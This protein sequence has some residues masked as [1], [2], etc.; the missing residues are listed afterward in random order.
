MIRKLKYRKWKKIIEKSELFDA[1]YYLFTYS[2]VRVQDIDPIK[3]YILHGVKEGRNPNEEFDT[4]FY[5]AN[6]PDVRQSNINP[7]VHYILYG[8]KENRKTFKEENSSA[9]LHHE[10]SSSQ[11]N[12]LLQKAYELLQK[13]NGSKEEFDIKYKKPFLS[14]LESHKEKSI[15][16]PSLFS[17]E[18][19]KE[20]YSDMQNDQINPL[21]HYLKHGQNE[22]R[23]GHLD[24]SSYTKQG[25]VDFDIKKETVVFV[26]HES[27]ASGAPLLGFGIAD[28][29]IEKYNIV[30]IV[31][32]EANIHEIFFSNCD[33]M[34]SDIQK[35]PY[36]YSY[37]FLK[38][39]LKERSI[40]CVMINSIVGY[41]VMYAAYKLDIPIVFLIHEFA[42]Y[43]RPFGTMIDAVLHSEIVVTPATI[44]Q[45]SIQKE[46]KRFANYKELPS[47]MHILPQG[48]LPY[49]PDS[50]GDD[51]TVDDLYN[52]LK[53]NKNE[54]VKIIVGSGWVQ[55]RK[56]VDLFVAVARYIK[57]LY[58]G[59]CKFIWVGEGFDPDNDL[60]YSVYLDREIEYSG[61]GDDFIFLEH[62]KN[63][64]NIFSIADVF[65]L[66]SR[67]DPFPNVAIDALSHD[68]HI[69]C[70]DDASGT[71]EFLRKHN[72]NCTI[73]DFVDTYKLAEGIVN[74]LQSNS[75]KEGINKKLLEEHL[76]FDK[77]VEQL[78][79][80]IEKA[81]SQKQEIREL[82]TKLSL[83][84]EFS[85]KLEKNSNHSS[86]LCQR[87]IENYIKN[88]HV[89]NKILSFSKE[90]RKNSN[91]EKE[92]EKKDLCI[93]HIGMPKTGSSAIEAALFNNITNI[94]V[95]Y[96]NLPRVNHS[97][98]IYSLFCKD[99]L[100]YHFIQMLDL[101]KKSLDIFNR[102]NKDLLIE[103]FLNNNTSTEIISGED[104]FH[105]KI[106]EVCELHDFLKFYFKRIIVIGY[107]RP[108]KSFIESAFQQYVK[109]HNISFFDS[110]LLYHPYKNFKNFDNVFGEEN[111]LLFKFEPNKFPDKNVV[112]HFT[113]YL[114]IRLK[115][116][117]SSMGVNESISKEAISILFTYHNFSDEKTNFG[118]SY[119]EVNE[120]LIERLRPIWNTKFKFSSTLINRIIEENE[121]DFSWIVHRINDNL[122]ENKVEQGIE[123]EFEL[124]Q[125]AVNYI[126]DLV[127]LLGNVPISFELVK[128][129]R[130]VAKLVDLIMNEIYIENNK[131]HIENDVIIGDN[132]HLFLAGGT[133]GVLKLYNDPNCFTVNDV[134]KWQ[135]I[136]S[137]RKKIL[138]KHKIKYFHLFIPDK[139]SI[140]SEYV[141]V[142]LKNFDSHPI[143]LLLKNVSCE[144]HTYVLDLLT[145]FM[146]VKQKKLLYRKT[147]THWTFDGCHMAFSLIMNKLGFS[148]PER[149]MK[150]RVTIVENVG[151]LGSKLKR[152]LSEKLEWHE[153][154][155]IA[156]RTFANEIVLLKEN[157]T[158]SI[159]IGLHVGS[160]VVFK[161]QSE[162]TVKK[163]V[164]IF[165][166]S[167]SSDRRHHL[168]GM[169]A[170][171]FCEV[172]FV[173]S[174]SLDYKYIFDVKPDI[175]ITDIAERFMLK[176]PDDTFDLSAYVNSKL[177]N[178]ELV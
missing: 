44:I 160:N 90:L 60:A 14:Y 30:H 9:I 144:L 137:S 166:D 161:N 158:N 88:I 157:K 40:K 16:I 128:N 101:N 75:K 165:G 48:K 173:W 34:F 20:L 103:G 2:D 58:N 36:I 81:V 59:K 52:K 74:Y 140:Y 87:Y 78:D 143:N 69:A 35:N 148:I 133:N 80:F 117:K 141:K 54:D 73:V 112:E 46:F 176:V 79:K 18:L 147:D 31:I 127:K 71:A 6:Y 66:S 102:R 82:R 139:I 126:D 164:V 22:G 155:I 64:D 114:D 146:K 118:K 72:A 56:G 68:L 116:K 85:E 3:H 5:L 76:D 99:A 174:T 19:Y 123:T 27:S 70:F 120:K 86:M 95:S 122:F 53:I 15:Y 28:K 162:D 107:V 84:P 159:N 11:K 38:Q 21:V 104:I 83:L 63:L 108:P 130:T 96:T 91:H 32:K 7:L 138:D 136:L 169:F 106:D 50:Y 93:L 47:N 151:D 17:S 10:N 61:L 55:I 67:M 26:S 152:P 145:P 98:A 115:D 150:H 134:I 13:N 65:C 149:F 25:K 168:T 110:S 178:E 119:Y 51:D 175:V 33:L 100:N 142:N 42:E 124:M 4:I 131:S 29:L 113:Q 156:E 41:Q 8:K 171:V 111:V 49:I 153:F 129:T 135:S 1:K 132:G 97:P 57:E 12:E 37:L 94:N 167:F 43:M 163:K 109:Y 24:L 154:S 105:L 170:E 125:Y 89:D 23:I 45:N 92:L 121:S 77:Y 177:K 39:L 172:H 62:Q